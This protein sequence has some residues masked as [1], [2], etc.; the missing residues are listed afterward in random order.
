MHCILWS[1]TVQ[2]SFSYR[3]HKK[4]VLWYTARFAKVDW[5]SMLATY[6][7]THAIVTKRWIHDWWIIKLRLLKQSSAILPFN[8]TL[9]WD[10]KKKKRK[11][12]CTEWQES[13]VLVSYNMMKSNGHRNTNQKFLKECQ[14]ST[15]RFCKLKLRYWSCDLLTPSLSAQNY[16]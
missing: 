5:S 11:R 9:H 6:M 10:S 8:N 16:F 2:D 4:V 3:T 12:H 14:Q 1:P 13:E 7:I 15:R